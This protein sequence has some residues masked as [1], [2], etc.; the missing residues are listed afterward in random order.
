M[1]Y[2]INCQLRL[3]FGKEIENLVSHIFMNYDSKTLSQYKNNGDIEKYLSNEYKMTVLKIGVKSLVNMRNELPESGLMEL[4][5]NIMEDS[6]KKDI[7]LKI[8]TVTSSG[9][10][11]FLVIDKR[12]EEVKSMSDIISDK[13][14]SKC[15]VYVDITKYVG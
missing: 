5:E 13:Y 12:Y 7:F 1:W 10:V 6:F 2:Y 11:F 8:F 4:I 3:K 15:N 14:F 9:P